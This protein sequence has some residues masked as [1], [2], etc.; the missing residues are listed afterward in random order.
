L[1]D[2]PNALSSSN[3]NKTAP[4]PKANL[5]SLIDN[6]RLA[7]NP[8][9]IHEITMHD[10]YWNIAQGVCSYT[11]HR[12]EKKENKMKKTSERDKHTQT[13]GQRQESMSGS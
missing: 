6:L 8:T 13:W 12:R 4:E 11:W 3:V 9:L 1:N 5:I 10:F 2:I 7:P